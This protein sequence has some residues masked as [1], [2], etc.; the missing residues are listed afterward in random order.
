MCFESRLFFSSSQRWVNIADQSSMAVPSSFKRIDNIGNALSRGEK[1][2]EDT[3]AWLSACWRSC[4]KRT[5]DQT[6][7]TWRRASEILTCAASG[8]FKI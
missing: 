4:R 7:H 6:F 2:R 5:L 3:E 8:G 1:R